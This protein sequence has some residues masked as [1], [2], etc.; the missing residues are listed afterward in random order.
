MEKQR[1]YEGGE[2]YLFV[3]YAHKDTQQAMPIIRGMMQRGYRVWYDGGL[4][5]RLENNHEWPSAIARHLKNSACVVV[6]LSEHAVESPNCR[7]ELT[8]AINRKKNPLVVMLEEIRWQDHDEDE[9]YNGVEMQIGTLHQFF[10][11]RFSSVDTLLDSLTR[12][13]AVSGTKAA[14]SLPAPG[15]EREIQSG[16]QPEKPRNDKRPAAEKKPAPQGK[17]TV[18]FYET[19]A[20][21]GDKYAQ[22]N[23]G[24]CY[25]TGLDVAKNWKEAA[26]WYGKAAVQGVVGAQY[27]LGMCYA[28]GRGVTKNWDE[29]ARWL[30]KA[31]MQGV[32][33]AQY[34]LSICFL[35]GWGISQN[36]E[37]G[38]RWSRKAAEQGHVMAQYQMGVCYETG[39]GVQKNKQKAV[40]L[41]QQASRKG[42]RE[43]VSALERLRS[44]REID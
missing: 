30:Q 25:A 12:V 18:G 40:A 36:P 42:C 44:R 3:S 28:M 22:Y 7:Q 33:D 16:P 14:Q 41:Y 2:P 27:Q 5:H 43:A 21:K 8:M 31:A 37:E 35:N 39:T 34:Q 38:F 17:N 29:A 20:L 6:L 13:R 19:L 11:N 10:R 15:R 26:M 23:L 24:V 32:V 1:I 4:D 9:R